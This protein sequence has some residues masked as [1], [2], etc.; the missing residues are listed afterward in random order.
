MKIVK[1]MKE[2]NKHLI[3][4]TQEKEELFYKILEENGGHIA[5]ACKE[6]GISTGT[7]KN[8]YG[9][10]ASFGNRCN[11]IITKMKL[12]KVKNKPPKI[13]IKKEAEKTGRPT[14]MTPETIKKLKEA[15]SQGFSIDNAC[16]WAEISKPTFYSYCDKE[17]GFL[18][19]CKTLQKKPLIKSIVIINKALDEGDLPT[20]K[21]LAER[22]GQDEYSLKTK[23]EHSGEIKSKVVYIEKEEKEEYENHINDTIN[24]AD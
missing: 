20:A 11:K 6:I 1:N 10:N 16:I 9:R 13:I 12:S 8:H 24:N 23:T 7:Y 5:N 3:A 14:M 15:F 17:E 2:A 21:W 19:Y 22:K 4:L 18:D